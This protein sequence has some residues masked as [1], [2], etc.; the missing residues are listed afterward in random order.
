MVVELERAV[1]DP[2]RKIEPERN[3]DEAL[4][5]RAPARAMRLRERAAQRREDGV[6]RTVGN[7]VDRQTRHVAGLGGR[8]EG[9]EARLEPAELFHRACFALGFVCS[10]GT[11]GLRRFE[12][13]I[14]RDNRL[15]L[16]AI[17]RRRT[18][19]HVPRIRVGGAAGV[20]EAV[21]KRG[22]SAERVLA[23]GRTAQVGPRG[24][25]PLRR[26]REDARASAR[27]RARGRRRHA[28][29]DP[30]A[31]LQRRPAGSARLRA[32]QRAQRRR[33]AAQSR[34]LRAHAPAGRPRR[35][36]AA[37]RGVP[38]RLRHPGRGPRAAAPERG[39]R[40][41]ALAPDDA[42]AD[43][44][45]V[46]T[47]A[48]GVRPSPAGRRDPTRACVRRSAALRSGAQLRAGLR[49]SGPRTTRAGS[50]RGHP[51]GRAALPRRH[52]RARSRRRRLAE[53][54]PRADRAQL[55]QRAPERG[56]D[57]AS[58][59]ALRPHA[60]ATPRRARAGL[61]DRWSRRSAATSRSAT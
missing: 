32:A 22:G 39:G 19:T 60:A 6:F 55:R 52:S 9:K 15:T 53:R 2:V 46:A 26:P 43:R 37:R 38:G 49:R 42:P 7:V 29:A 13:L 33:R 18:A 3:R 36:R 4:A 16:G 24:S 21:A 14:F 47:Q 41:R 40:E 5:Q 23:R 8:L 12:R 34:A 56:A 58:A 31:H 44:S 1:L 45:G 54:G 10:G 50:G 59:R 61:E 11:I 20:L 25:R 51:A 30:R 27:S 57:R 28:R 48:R 17:G 35:G